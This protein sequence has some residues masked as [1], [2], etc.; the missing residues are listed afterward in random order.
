[1]DGLV[2]DLRLAARALR[3]N[4]TLAISVVATLALAI[5]A[6]VATFAIAEAALITP[7]P[8]PDP[9][10]LVMLYTTHTAPS[11]GTQ[12]LRWSYPRS[13]MLARSLTTT[14][15]VGSYGLSSVNLGG[16]SEA[17]PVSAEPV[18]GDYFAALG[19]Q[20]A[21]GRLFSGDEDRSPSAAPIAL[22]GHEL[23]QRRYAGDPAVIGQ[24]VRVNGS[25]LA[26]IGV[27][28]AGFKGLTG[29]AELW[30]PGVQTPH[31]TYPEYLTTNQD[32][33]SVVARLRPTAS[34]EALRAELSTVGPAIQ[35]AQPSQSQVPGDSFGATAVALR[36]VRVNPTTRRAMLVLLGAV[37]AVILLACANVSSLLLTHAASRRREMAVRLALGATRGRLVRQ[38]LTESALLASLGGAIGLGLAWWATRTIVAPAGGLAPGNFYGS[39]GEF[40]RPRIDVTLLAFTAGVTILTALLCGLAPA[41]TAARTTLAT[42]LRQSGAVTRAGSASRFSLRGMAVAVEVALALVLL[43]GGSLMLATLARLRGESIGIDPRNVIAFAIRPPEVRYATAAAPMFIERLLA[44]IQTVPGVIAATVDGCAPLVP[45]CANSSLYIV[46]RPAPRPGEAPGIMRHYV[47][48]EHF[49]VL[50]IPVLRGRSFASTDRSG[51]PAVAIINQTAARRF[52]PNGNP[53][54]ARIWFGGGSLWSSPDSTLEVV[55]VVG[56]VP[57]Q[58]GDDRRARPAVYTSYLQ[59]TYSTRTVMVRTSGDAAAALR[60]VRDAVRSIDPDLA[61]YEFGLL[62]EQLGGAWAKQRFTSGVL[63]AFAVLALLLAAT[64]VFGVVASLVSE[65]TREIGIRMALGATP[66]DVG[67]LVVRQG[68]TL[69]IAGIIAGMVLAFP[70]AQSLRGLLYGISPTDPRAFI[71]VVLVLAGVSLLATFIPA[72][73][74]TRVDPRIAMSAE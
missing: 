52:W 42:T 59:F 62:T 47:G 48:P 46:G 73:R 72:R 38:L 51:R 22:I 25:D 54:G 9:D 68:M 45:S 4:R 35:R 53:I 36:D 43:V 26:I 29:R 11:R 16:R 57:Y 3:R 30:Y 67:R 15:A 12:R 23:W 10:R 39:V 69:P 18:S 58:E 44:A 13:R 17:E 40:V 70:A 56:D 5:G 55:G 20:P 14:A 32:F 28:P 31:L 21:R 61:L 41:L 19:V 24:T 50:D 33:I 64:G 66:A 37:G 7:P 2:G 1:M 49:R 65:R 74:A 27:M 63:V 8:F 71:V 60:G 34:I 6:G